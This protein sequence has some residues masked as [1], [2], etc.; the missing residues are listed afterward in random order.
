MSRVKKLKS[1]TEFSDYSNVNKLNKTS[2][3]FNIDLDLPPTIT[4]NNIKK[5]NYDRDI[6]LKCFRVN[7]K[8]NYYYIIINLFFLIIV[9]L[10]L[11][12]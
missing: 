1:M 11:Q 7:T 8:F 3:A 4:E 6:E 10:L 12:H 2:N 9:T 5:L